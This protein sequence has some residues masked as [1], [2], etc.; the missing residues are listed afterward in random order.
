M[1]FD[2]IT[3]AICT[4]N[5]SSDLNAAL[6]SL[7]LQTAANP[8]A[9]EILVVDNGS[10][11]NSVEV[12]ESFRERIPFSLKVVVEQTKGLSFARNTAIKEAGGDIVAFLD[13]D[14]TVLPGWIDAHLNAYRSD[15]EVRGVMGRII[16][17]WEAPRPDWLDPALDSYITVVDFG[18]EPFTLSFPAHSPVGANMS[19][20]RQ[21]LMDVGMFDVRYGVGGSKQIPFEEIE[22]AGRFFK[23]GWKMVYWPEAAVYHGVPANRATLK[24]FSR[25]IF[26]QGRAQYIFDRDNMGS[27]ALLAKAVSG[28]F[29]KGPILAAAA[30][31]DYF[32][33]KRARAA[34]RASVS[35]HNLGYLKELLSSP[36]SG[37]DRDGVQ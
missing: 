31:V 30:G 18:E 16:P 8:A 13:D 9:V 15:P 10:P 37:K 29:V 28:C 14:A 2:T 6:E 25:R 7:A 20:G 34:K 11:D 33:G 4:Y 22:L 35:C 24:W 32:L 3:V 23:R 26:S 1:S 36:F 27:A 12:A 5:R 19:F 21:E 17:K